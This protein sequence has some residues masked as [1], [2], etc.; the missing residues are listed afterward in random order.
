M[1][2]LRRGSQQPTL[3]HEPPDADDWSISELAIDYAAAVGYELD[4]WQQDMVRWSFVR[5]RDGLWSARDYGIEV[6]RQNGKNIVLEV[7]EVV[8]LFALGEDLVIH[9]AHRTDVSHEHFLSLKTH[10]E[11][12]PD[13][14]EQ[15][16]NRPNN[17]FITANGKESIEL[18]NGNRLLFKSRQSG[19]G[20][21]PRPKR[22]VFDEAL[23]LSTTAVGDMAPGMTAQRNPQIIF[24]SS[25]PKSDS[26]MLHGLRKRAME[27]AEGDRLFY[28][29]WNNPD[30]TDPDDQ[31][32]WYR[33]NPSLGYGRMTEES[34]NANRRL[35]TFEDFIR[36]HIGI[37]EPP[38]DEQ[39]AIDLARWSELAYVLD[40]P[41]TELSDERI[42]IDAAG[43]LRSVTFGQA[44]RHVA[45]NGLYVQ[46]RAHLERNE[47]HDRRPLK[48]RTIEVAVKLCEAY[49]PLVVRANSPV[50][51]WR[52]EMEN[53]GVTFD[54]LSTP[55]YAAA[56]GY[57]QD[58]VEEGT[59]RHRNQPEMNNAVA[60]L[61]TKPAGDGEV[62]SH[63]K[64]SAN[65]A[66]FVAVTCALYRVPDRVKRQ[67]VFMAVT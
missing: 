10:I 52:V 26:S 20:R 49:G 65:I 44:A 32:A 37:P 48:T 41:A 16:P 13:L 53:A 2:D 38:D 51:A 31:D 47:R 27:P 17:G 39:H 4:E 24:A 63:R 55:D 19:S 57:I 42:G 59:I 5:R 45:T 35:M 9:S 7:I 43:G 1:S 28:A 61:G 36:E 12:T 14:M 21:G 46:W 30:S 15:M 66:P 62:W 34:L 40:D 29:A 33:V 60:G 23:I 67:Q 3:L 18:A 8:A 64:S 54:E 50:L 11:S 22:L 58:A 6:P 56:C 25:P